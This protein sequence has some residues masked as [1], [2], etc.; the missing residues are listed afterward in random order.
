MLTVHEAGDLPYGADADDED[1][2][3]AVLLRGDRDA[4]RLAAGHLYQEVAVVPAAELAR[5][6]A[7]VAELELELFACEECGEPVDCTCGV[8]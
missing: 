8:E 2:I 5:L 6:R 1:R 7:R 3:P 4:V